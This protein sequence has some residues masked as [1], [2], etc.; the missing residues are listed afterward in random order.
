MYIQNIT[1]NFYHCRCRVIGHALMNDLHCLRIK[2]GKH[3]DPTVIRDT[4]LHYKERYFCG[5]KIDAALLVTLQ[6]LDYSPFAGVASRI[7][8][9]VTNFPHS[10][11][12]QAI[13][14]VQPENISKMSSGGK[15]AAGWC[16]AAQR[17]RGCHNYDEA[18]LV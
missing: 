11:T 1:C 13:R 3:L 9:I 7:S 15:C 2:E 8:S 10:T 18:L 12:L 4:Q 16:T 6:D 17:N 14:S 5:V